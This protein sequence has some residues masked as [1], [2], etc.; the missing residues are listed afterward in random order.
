VG[1]ITL[2]EIALFGIALV[3]FVIGVLV[4]LRSR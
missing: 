2:M 3:V 4:L 1:V